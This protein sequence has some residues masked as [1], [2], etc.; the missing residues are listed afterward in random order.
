MPALKVQ[1]NIVSAPLGR[2]LTAFA[3]GQVSVVG[4]NLPAWRIEPGA[5][6]VSTVLIFNLGQSIDSQTASNSY[7]SLNRGKKVLLTMP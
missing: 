4:I 7:T 5:I 3:L 2:A 1:E 6:K